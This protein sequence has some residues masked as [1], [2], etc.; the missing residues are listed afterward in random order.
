MRAGLDEELIAPAVERLERFRAVHVVHEDAAVRSTVESDTERLE[1]FL[2]S[3]I[4]QLFHV[5]I[6]SQSVS[7]IWA[8][9]DEE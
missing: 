3:S 8:V 1:P 2:A 5:P 9:I 7:P 6:S 4:P